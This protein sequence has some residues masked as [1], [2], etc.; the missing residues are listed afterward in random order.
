MNCENEKQLQVRVYCLCY[1][2]CVKHGQ[3]VVLYY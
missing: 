1:Y 2:K 3:I